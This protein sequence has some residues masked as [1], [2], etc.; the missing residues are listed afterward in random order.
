MILEYVCMDLSHSH[1]HAFVYHYL[2]SIHKEKCD[3][4]NF[5]QIT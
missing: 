3:H 4:N 2:Q 1:T 5:K